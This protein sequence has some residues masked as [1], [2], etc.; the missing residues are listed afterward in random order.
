M[1][2]QTRTLYSLTVAKKIKEEGKEIKGIVEDYST[3]S[4]KKVV[5]DGNSESSD[6]FQKEEKKK[7]S[8]EINRYSKNCLNTFAIGDVVFARWEE[9]QVWYNAVVKEVKESSMSVT[10]NDYGNE[11]DIDN[12]NVVRTS[13]EIPLDGIIDENVIT[14]GKTECKTIVVKKVKGSTTDSQNEFL[15]KDGFENSST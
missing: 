14:S 2:M 10:F 9:D 12:Y 13:E 15:K 5:R 3:D 1:T 6:S 4:F 8:V 7:R 11:A